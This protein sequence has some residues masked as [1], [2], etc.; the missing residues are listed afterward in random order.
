ML[1]APVVRVVIA[2]WA[3]VL[4]ILGVTFLVLGAVA[5][6][7]VVVGVATLAPGVL[8]ALVTWVLHARA[9]AERRRRH[10][11]ERVVAEVVRARLHTMARIGVMLTYTLT[12]R[13]A[14]VGAAAAEFTRQVLAPPTHPLRVGQRIEICYDPHDPEN[15]EPL[16]DVET[17]P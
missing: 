6:Q 17:S 15:F 12:V 2:I 1:G 5:G 9:R 11:G 16:W 7:A 3:L 4:L 8:L 10:E 14:P 13:F